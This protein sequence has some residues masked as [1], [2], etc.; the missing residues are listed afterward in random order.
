M[1]DYKRE[2][3]DNF[4]DLVAKDS[5]LSNDIL[6]EIMSDEIIQSNLADYIIYVAGL[7]GKGIGTDDFQANIDAR[8]DQLK[9]TLLKKFKKTIEDVSQD[10]IERAYEESEAV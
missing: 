10:Y 7:K 2:K 3:W 9:D 4:C 6:C 1:R 5:S 8:V